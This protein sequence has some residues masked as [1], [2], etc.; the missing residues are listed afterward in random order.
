MKNWLKRIS[1]LFIKTTLP[2]FATGL[3][4]FFIILNTM[5]NLDNIPALLSLDIDF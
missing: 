4:V 3:F 2:Y 5:N 1:V